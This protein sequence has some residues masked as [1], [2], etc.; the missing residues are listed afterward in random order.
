M[1]LFWGL[2]T[3]MCVMHGIFCV[4]EES[5]DMC[6]LLCFALLCCV[7]H[8]RVRSIVV[9][10]VENVDA[11]LHHLEVGEEDHVHDA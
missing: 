8:S 4:F 10:C 3:A 7:H 11:F 6:V 5:E 1:T 2:V 9:V